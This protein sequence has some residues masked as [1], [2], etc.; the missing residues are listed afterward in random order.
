MPILPQSD[1]GCP[2]PGSGTEFIEVD[3]G[4]VTKVYGIETAGDPSIGAWVTSL[5]VLYSQDGIAYS[6]ISNPDGSPQGTALG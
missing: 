2:N 1:L 6:Q 4:K 3:L 5:N